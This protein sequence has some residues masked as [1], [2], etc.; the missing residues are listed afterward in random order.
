MPRNINSAKKTVGIIKVWRLVM[1][2]KLSFSLFYFFTRAKS[3]IDSS[4]SFIIT[5]FVR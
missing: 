4:T 2:A 3:V 1:K 5:F